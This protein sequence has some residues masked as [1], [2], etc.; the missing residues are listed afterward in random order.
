M[1]KDFFRRIRNKKL[2]QIFTLLLSLTVVLSAAL[3]SFAADSTDDA[4][5]I[6]SVANPVLEVK[7]LDAGTLETRF[8][9][10]IGHWGETYINTLVDLHVLSG[11]PDGLFHPDDLVTIPEYVTMIIKSLYGEQPPADDGYWASVYMQ[12]GLE[13][14][15]VELTDLDFGD[16]Y[17]MTRLDAIRIGYL[18]VLHLGESL[19]SDI[20]A[21]SKL[22]DLE[23][24]RSCREPLEQMYAKGI[25][26]GR[27]PNFFDGEGNLTR[28]EAC[29]IALKIMDKEMRTPPQGE[30]AASDISSNANDTEPAASSETNPSS[31]ESKTSIAVTPA[32]ALTPEA[33]RELMED[34]A[35]DILLLDVRTEEEHAQNHIP[36]SICI[37]V[38]QLI[39]S[40]A[41]ALAEYKDLPIIVYCK[42]GSRTKR[43][44]DFLLLEGFSNLYNLV[45]GTDAWPY[46]L[47]TD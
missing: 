33:A 17:D 46:K 26:L 15:I 1:K 7:S 34:N 40:K 38:D 20:S 32:T 43:A 21:A 25:I 37:P 3:C 31:P 27:R 45:G 42:A 22:E 39:S 19:E 11:M 36:G 10:T 23:S 6:E 16:D 12:R 30:N 2:L 5:T 8:P 35:N 47:E 9:D 24:C 28:A 41:A 13:T 44:V 29:V 4:C 14:G 18:T